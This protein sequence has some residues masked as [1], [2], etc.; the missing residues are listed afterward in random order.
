L[1]RPD[2][3]RRDPVAARRV[4]AADLLA[5][6]REVFFPAVFLAAP[7]ADFFAAGFLVAVLFV[8]ALRVDFLAAGFL[9][10]ADLLD[11]AFV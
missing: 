11:L 2:E 10:V 4:V 8:V 5:G 6:W 7:A 3:A 1:E 9:V